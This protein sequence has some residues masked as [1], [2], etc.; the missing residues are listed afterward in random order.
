MNDWKPSPIT[1]I[2]VYQK[3]DYVRSFGNPGPGTL[4]VALVS[5]ERVEI[6]PGH[7]AE[8]VV[9]ADGRFTKARAVLVDGLGHE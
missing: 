3:P 6:P 2:V 9:R 7:R 8:C 5:G 4:W 1:G